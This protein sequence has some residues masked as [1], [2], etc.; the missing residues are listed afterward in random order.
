MQSERPG[1]S[2]RPN[3]WERGTKWLRACTHTQQA[4][5]T[6][7]A[8][9]RQIHG[10]HAASTRHSC[11]VGGSLDD[12]AER[13][14]R[15]IRDLE[16]GMETVNHRACDQGTQRACTRHASG[17]HEA[18][19]RHARSKPGTTVHI[20]QHPQHVGWRAQPC[21]EDVMRNR[22]GLGY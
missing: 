17:K 19:T 18:C 22:H 13:P 15:T 20:L 12:V 2:R 6:P 7:A 4:H 10:T 16:A 21:R 1:H 14:C 3:G 8:R 5:D 11:N 9:N